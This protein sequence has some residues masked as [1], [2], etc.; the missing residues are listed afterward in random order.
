[1]K[2]EDIH[3]IALI[4][5]GIMGHG[6]AQTFATSGYSVTVTD[7]NQG[8]LDTLFT[9]IGKNLTTFAEAGL[10]G[11]Y[12]LKTGSGFFSHTPEEWAEITDKGD[13]ILLRRLK[14]L[15]G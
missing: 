5:A 1:M 15:Y 9:R 12:G 3:R 8:A 11:D 6:I 4:G 14:C 13:R 2:L 10:A 7:M